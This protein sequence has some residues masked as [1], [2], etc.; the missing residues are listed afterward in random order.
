VK[1]DSFL[2]NLDQ[3]GGTFEGMAAQGIGT[4]VGAGLGFLTPVVGGT[5]VGA[6]VGNAAGAIAGAYLDARSVAL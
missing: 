4:A 6:K 2:K 1:D 3:M 5:A